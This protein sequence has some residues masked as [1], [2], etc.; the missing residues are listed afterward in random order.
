MSTSRRRPRNLSWLVPGKSEEGEGTRF[1][2]PSCVSSARHRRSPMWSWLAAEAAEQAEELTVD[3]CSLNPLAVAA[4]STRHAQHASKPGRGRPVL[5]HCRDMVR[6]GAGSG[7][8]GGGSGGSRGHGPEYGP[9]KVRARRAGRDSR[10]A[11][12]RCPGACPGTTPTTSRTGAVASLATVPQMG[13]G[14]TLFSI[15]AAEGPFRNQWYPVAPRLSPRRTMLR[16]GLEAS[17]CGPAL[18]S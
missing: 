18:F 8:N 12:A 16:H 6:P 1:I 13:S 9:T 5:G 14:S 3:L 15:I 7:A 2:R 10:A 17:T 11:A 4:S